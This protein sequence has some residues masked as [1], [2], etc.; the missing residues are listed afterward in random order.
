[1]RGH[2]RVAAVFVSLVFLANLAWA[3]ADDKRL[4]TVTA[5]GVMKVD[6]DK[7]LIKLGVESWNAD[8]LVA[9]RQNDAKLKKIQTLAKSFKMGNDDIEVSRISIE[10][11]YRRG[12]PDFTGCY[13]RRTVILKLKEVSKFEDVLLHS[14][15]A[16]AN[17]I[18]SIEFRTTKL[19]DLKDQARAKAIK[20][21]KQKAG[22]M[23]SEL[24]KEV[25]TPH[26]IRED[27]CKWYTASG[28]KKGGSSS[29]EDSALGK[30][31]VKSKV[32]ISFELK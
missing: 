2:A 22:T 8:P 7:A 13:I 18:H 23:A 24:G 25:G 5:E 26:S 12:V 4:I 32:T 31:L 3:D 16:G 29:A 6:P 21:A 15:K 17:K 11:T 19:K 14:L 28:G 30:I 1:M 27:E 10:P 9:K 20:A